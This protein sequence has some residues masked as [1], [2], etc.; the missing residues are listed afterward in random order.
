MATFFYDPQA[1]AISFAGFTMQGFGPDTFVECTPL[2]KTF[3]DEVGVDGEVTRS[4]SSDRRVR[5]KVSL[6][7]TSATNAL[8]SN[9]LTLDEKAPNGAGVSQFRM[10]DLQGGTF[11]QGP[12]AWIE[13]WP[14]T[15][16]GKSGKM[17]EWTIL[18]GECDQFQGG[19]A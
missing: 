18:I 8:M 1:V 6:A 5:V 7:Q 4:K 2:S 14:V 3:I 10:A 11:V 17:R 19:N 12:Q 15:T 16:M 13:G 9:Q